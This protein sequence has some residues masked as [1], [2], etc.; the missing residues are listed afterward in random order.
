M[1]VAIM[2]KKKSGEMMSKGM[3]R[4][5]RKYGFHGS[6]NKAG[7]RPCVKWFGRFNEVGLTRLGVPAMAICVDIGSELI[8]LI[9]DRPADAVF[10]SSQKELN[11]ILAEEYIVLKQIA[12]LLGP[13]SG[14]YQ[15]E[16][17]YM[18][19]KR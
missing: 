11:G 18:G 1:E 3:G 10:Q 9:G 19:T 8:G 15:R 5:L 6:V 2:G 13:C 16:D 17:Y 12:Y 4:G 14:M 7:I